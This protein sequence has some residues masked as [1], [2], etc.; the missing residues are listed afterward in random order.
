MLVRLGRRSRWVRSDRRRLAGVVVIALVVILGG[1]MLRRAAT[2][3]RDL[4]A[5]VDHLQQARP[6]LQPIMQFDPEAWPAS[7]EIAEAR[8]DLSEANRLLDRARGRLGY[9]PAAGNAFGWVPYWGDSLANGDDALE[10]GQELVAASDRLMQRLDD[11]VAGDGRIAD[12]AHR[13]FVEDGDALLDD[14]DTLVALQEE[15]ERLQSVVWR[16]PFARA[17]DYLDLAGTDLARASE[18]RDLAVDIRAGLPTLLGYDEP[19]TLLLLGQNDHEVRATGG[20]IGTAGIIT[21]EDGRVT[22]RRFA[23]SYELDAPEGEARRLP[24]LEMQRYLGIGEWH[25]RDANFSP[26]FREA[27]SVAL[28]FLE[29]DQGITADAV[30]AVDSHFVALLLGALGTVPVE[31]FDE[32]LTEEN[33]FVQ[34]ENAIYALEFGASAA[35]SDVGV[36]ASNLVAN[37]SFE[38]SEAGWSAVGAAEVTAIAVDAPAFGEQSLRVETTAE[39]GDGARYAGSANAPGGATYTASLSVRAADAAS[40]GKTVQVVVASAG[41]DFEQHST[42]AV[43]G[44]GWDRVTLTYSWAAGTHVG[45]VITVRDAIGQSV[46]FEVDGVQV[47]AGDTATPYDAARDAEDAIRHAASRSAAR[48]AYLGPVLDELLHRAEEASGDTVPGLLASLQ[49]AAAERHLQLF[50]PHGDVQALATRFDVD[51]SLDA[52]ES[53][54]LL[55]VVDMNVSYNKIQPAISRSILYLAGEGGL[56]DVAVTWRNDLPTFD[57]ERYARLGRDGQLWQHAEYRFELIPGS[58]AS[59]TRLFI[60]P[61]AELVAARGFETGPGY[62]PG[63]DLALISG[64]VVVPPGESVTVY[65]TYRLPETPERVS[66]WRQGGFQSSDVRVLQNH[67]GIQETLFAG[68]LVEDVVVELDAHESTEGGPR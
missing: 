6:V 41:A 42:T 48:Q 51:G 38:F 28:D 1:D 4:D 52:P 27:A 57:G 39:A 24:P 12:R 59:Y 61:D 54:D 62:R 23:A 64:R 40:V 37:P 7:E 46:A 20:F 5:A 66:V 47:E 16:G 63:E 22:S 45:W 30:V 50:S 55:A 58:Y 19:R 36:A 33:W 65:V 14:L 26:D 32:P 21:V 49:Q 8:A 13:T 53:G 17:S 2:G 56:V 11:L 35:P 60:P 67:E 34:A 43:L 29:Q 9:L 25:I 18:A 3:Y 44:A 15:V 10:T 31:G 68:P